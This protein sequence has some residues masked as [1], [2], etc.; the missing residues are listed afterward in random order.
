MI[1]VELIRIL[2]PDFMF[3]DERGVLFQ[4]THEPFGQTNA[5]F[6]K[7]GAVRGGYHYHKETKEAF[8]VISGKVNVSV[9]LSGKK[10]EHIFGSGDMFLIDENVRHTFEYLEDTY[11]VAFYTT[12]V[13]KE[14][15]S[16]DIYPDD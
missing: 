15:G 8:F 5:V 6:T 12:C 10:E 16:K 7:K 2:K 1:I 4:I 14:D 11:L 13:E 3:E 9:K